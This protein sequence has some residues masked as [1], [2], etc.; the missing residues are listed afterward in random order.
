MEKVE[1]GNTVKAQE[2]RG[3]LCNDYQSSTLIFLKFALRQ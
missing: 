3:T 2:A 1:L